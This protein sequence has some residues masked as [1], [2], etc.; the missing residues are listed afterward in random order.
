MYMLVDC[1]YDE[2]SSC[3][4]VFAYMIYSPSLPNTLCVSVWTHKYPPTYSK[5]IQRIL[6]D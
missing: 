1:F 6:E 5:G 3:L 4:R 2:I